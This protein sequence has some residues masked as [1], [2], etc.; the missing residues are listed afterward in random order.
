MGTQSVSQFSA[1][2]RDLEM[3]E[4]ETVLWYSCFSIP[5]SQL[6]LPG[7]FS[8]QPEPSELIHMECFVP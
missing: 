1:V 2:L 8:E 6:L 3:C 4:S 5:G 7:Q